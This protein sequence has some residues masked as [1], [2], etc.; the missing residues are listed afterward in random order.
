MKFLIIGDLHGR[1]PRIHYKDSDAIIAP[2]DFCSDKELGPI[3]K[4]WFKH[5]KK[6]SGKKLKKVPEFDEFIGKYA[7]KK[8]VKNMEKRSL[9]Q[10]RKILK[11]LNSFGK[12]VFI[13]PGN[14]DQSYGP[15]RIKDINKNS[16]TYRKA[17]ADWWLGKYTNK[18]LT[19][20]LKNIHDCQYKLH[21]FQEFNIIGYGLSSGPEA[22]KSKYKIGDSKKQD[23]KKLNLAYKKLVKQ[24]DSAYKTRDRSKPTIFLSHNVPYKTKVD[25]VVNK[26]S[27]AHN[28]HVGSSVARQFCERHKPIVCI[29]GHVHEHHKKTTMKGTPVINAGYGAKVNTL[30]ETKNGKIKDIK[31]FG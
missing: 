2:G 12:P 31:F 3:Y 18:K 29:G 4:K 15:T 24:L 7:S 26:A 30:L 17:F 22:P 21:K 19:K 10:G 5:L 9:A 8:E 25:V 1:M 11:F 16:Y 13:T 23:I 28:L 6:Y 20:G 14:W 27:Y